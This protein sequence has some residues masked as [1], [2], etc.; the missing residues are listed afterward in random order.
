MNATSFFAFGLALVGTAATF[1][2]SAGPAIAAPVETRAIALVVK[3]GDM[4]SV[5]ARAALDARIARAAR[6]VCGWQAAERSLS[7]RQQQ[8][9]CVQQAIRDSKEQVAQRNGSVTAM[10]AR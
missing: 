10:V 2:I 4:G 5:S 1:A 8:R 3:P 6:Q 9:A 7:N